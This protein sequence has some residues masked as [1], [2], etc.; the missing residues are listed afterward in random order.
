MDEEEGSQLAENAEVLLPKVT[1][2]TLCALNFE[3][4]RVSF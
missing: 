1:Q 2:P 3:N 4:G